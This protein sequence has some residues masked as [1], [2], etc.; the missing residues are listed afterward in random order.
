VLVRTDAD[1]GHVPSHDEG[2]NLT[3]AIC[4]GLRE[5]GE[6]IGDATV[7]D[8]ELVPV[9]QPPLLIAYSRCLDSRRIGTRLRFGQTKCSDHLAG[10][11]LRIVPR[12]LFISS[13]QQQTAHSNRTV[14]THG[15]GY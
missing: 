12:L 15:N 13:E 9:E 4:T 7:R 11:E 2:A 10:R 5:H 14:C 8:P 6:K 1:A 3:P